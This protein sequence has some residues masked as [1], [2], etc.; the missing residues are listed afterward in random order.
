MEDN[1][2]KKI[3]SVLL[4][5]FLLIGCMGTALAANGAPQFTY[6]VSLTNAMGDT[7]NDVTALE[8]GDKV[9]F[10][11]DVTRTDITEDSYDAYTVEFKVTSNGL[12]FN[13]DGV[14][15]RDGT[16][17]TSVQY[18]NGLVT[19]VTYLD[20]SL[21]GE[22]VSNPLRVASWSYTVDDP[23]KVSLAVTTAIVYVTGEDNSSTP[24]E[25]VAFSLNAKGG[26]VSGNPSGEY[27]KGTVI[28]LPG[29]TR[30]GY[31]FKGWSDGSTVYPAGAELTLN[32]SMQ[33]EAQWEREYEPNPPVIRPTKP[34]WKLPYKVDNLTTDKHINYIVGYAD[35]TIR[36]GNNI[37]RA[38]VATIFYRLLTDECRAKYGT[39]TNSFSDVS[40][41][42][43]HNKAIST[44]ANAGVLT[45]YP[46]GTFGP[47]RSIT[48]AELVTI[49]D[50]FAEAEGGVASF[51][52][53]GTHWA[54]SSIGSSEANSWV[55]GY[56]DGSFKPNGAITRAETFAVVNRLLGRY[57]NDVN[58]L[59]SGMETF[60]D[61]LDT[62]KWYY[63]DIQEA[64]N[65]HEYK[66]LDGTK[67]EKWTELVANIDY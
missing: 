29:A 2:L 18:F 46:D 11:I 61:N 24:V 65:Y 30:S 47:S 8:A 38:E 26:S 3:I 25:L 5:V 52:D 9:N 64:A 55:N 33:L 12:S 17:V 40:E 66:R 59:L 34:E 45:G 32:N 6:T 49:V 21:K 43:W 37:T 51:F 62:T 14:A 27:V 60:S 53:V 19:G 35:G 22:T 63:F 4:A 39:T 1:N 15:F 44:L 56:P 57:V 54:A 41:G 10:A 20:L 58:C 48:R 42:Q 31:T 13:G 36:P 7:I 67:Y 50:R 23:A 16:D 28:T